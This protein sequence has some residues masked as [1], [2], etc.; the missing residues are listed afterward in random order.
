M[1][2]MAEESAYSAINNRWKCKKV[3]NIC[4][5]SPCISITILPLALVIET[6]HLENIKLEWLF[7]TT[8]LLKSEPEGTQNTNQV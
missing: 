8:T 6:I 4:A 7:K 2:K 3:K 5:V 1:P